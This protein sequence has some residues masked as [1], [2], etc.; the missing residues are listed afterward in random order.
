MKA[1]HLQQEIEG[2][3]RARDEA[4]KHGTVAEYVNA[5]DWHYRACGRPLGTSFNALHLWLLYKT[6]TT[7]N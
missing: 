2:A 7:A 5:V 4:M 6:A 3:V 1:V